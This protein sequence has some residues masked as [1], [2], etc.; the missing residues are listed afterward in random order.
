MGEGGQRHAKGAQIMNLQD[1]YW[2]DAVDW[3]QDIYI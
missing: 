2:G 3:Q 1:L